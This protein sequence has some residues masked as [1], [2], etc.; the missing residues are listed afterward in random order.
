MKYFL[1]FLFLAVIL[2]MPGC[3]K[4]TDQQTAFF[5]GNAQHT[6]VYNSNAPDNLHGDAWRF[7]TGGRVFSSP[8]ISNNMVFIGSD[9]GNMYALDEKDGKPVWVYSTGGRISST[10]A[11]YQDRVY[12]ISF[13]GFFYCLDRLSGDLVWKFKTDG[14]KVFAAPNIHGIQAE[15]KIIDDPYDLFLSS[16]TVSEGTVF[17]GTGKGSVYAL[18]ARTGEKIWQKVTGNVVHSSPVCNDSAVFIGSWDSYLYALDKRT[19]AEKWK[20]KTGTDT[21]YY[22]QVGFQSS[23][24]LYKGMI[25]SGCRDAHVWA[26]DASTGKM[27]WNYYNNGSWVICTPAVRNDT[28]FFTTS[29]THKL[30]AVDALTGKELYTGTCLSYGFSSPALAGHML[31]AGN[32]GGSLIAFNAGNGKQ[33]WEFKTQAAMLNADSLLTKNGELNT[34]MLYKENS[35]KGAIESVNKLFSL[36]SIISSPAIDKGMVFFGSTNG[37]VYAVY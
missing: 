25:Y 31:L 29:D 3:K 4:E 23:P 14:E 15:G 12:F 1:S 28:L 10:A 11:I 6:G 16:A 19:G 33:V 20:F 27:K 18:D 34:A 24:V 8:V 32:S 5:H 13:D 9:D 30:I 21:V 35:Y 17:F 37:N 26:I 22:N 36:G 7:K 2:I